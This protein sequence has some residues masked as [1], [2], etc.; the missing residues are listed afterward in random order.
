MNC[1]LKY[2]KYV[3]IFRIKFGISISK[4]LKE[5]INE[6]M[7][8]NTKYRFNILNFFNYKKAGAIWSLQ[9][10]DRQIH[11]RLVTVAHRHPRYLLQ[12]GHH[13]Q[14]PTQ[15]KNAL[16]S[17]HIKPVLSTRS[18]RSISSHSSKMSA[19]VYSI[20]NPLNLRVCIKDLIHYR[21]GSCHPSFSWGT[22]LAISFDVE[23]SS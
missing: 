17:Y 16:F 6:L 1:L 14:Y 23:S 22:A 15:Q 3:I 21:A 8:N 11:S 5:S 12:L 10:I 2:Y 20:I 18:T 19:W 9:I 7:I 13:D 4:Y